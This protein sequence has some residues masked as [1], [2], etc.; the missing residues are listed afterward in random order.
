MAVTLSII[1]VNS[2]MHINAYDIVRNYIERGT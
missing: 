1:V 2:D